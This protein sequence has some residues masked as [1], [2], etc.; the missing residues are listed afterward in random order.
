[1]RDAAMRQFE[2]RVRVAS[3]RILLEFNIHYSLFT[4]PPP[5]AAPHI[6][7]LSREYD[8]RPDGFVVRERLLEFD[9]ASLCHLGFSRGVV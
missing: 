8:L 1:M 4:I 6:L 7:T 3:E 9:D 2:L 5:A